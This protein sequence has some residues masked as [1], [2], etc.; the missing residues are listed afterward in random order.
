MRFIYLLC[1]LLISGSFLIAQPIHPVH[2]CRYA[3]NLVHPAKPTTH[4]KNLEQESRLRSDSIDLLNYTIDLEVDFNRSEVVGSCSIDFMP[5]ID[6]TQALVLDLLQLRIDSVQLDGEPIAYSYDEF[7]INIPL[8]EGFDYSIQ[9]QVQVHY[10][11]RPTVAASGFGG[12]AFAGNIAY[13]LGIGLGENPYN[14]GRSWF[15]CFDNFVERAT[16]DLNIISSGNNK[17]YCSG[18]FIE[19]V[20]LNDNQ[21]RRS[22]RINEPM[23]TYLVGI[24]VSTFT[25]IESSHTGEYGTYPIQLVAQPQQI[26]DMDDSF[27]FLGDAVDAL[28]SW[29]GPYSW[30]RIGYVL[31]PIGAMEHVH[32]IAYPIATGTGGPTFDQNRLMAHE[33]AHQWW[34]NVTTLSS[35][36]NMWIKE[37]NAEYGAHLFTEYVQGKEAF[38]AQMQS[39]QLMVLSTAHLADDGFQPLSGIPYE[40]TYGV[41]TYNK[42][43]AVLHN[44]RSYMGDSLFSRAQTAVLRDLAFTSVD[45][46]EYRDYLST[47][48][49]LDMGPFFDAWI[50]APGF[51]DYE[52]DKMTVTE[53]G[54]NYMVTVEVQQKLRATEAYHNNEPVAITFFDE[55]WTQSTMQMRA[56]GE[57]STA[58]FRMPFAPAM[59][60][61][62]HEQTLNM[63]RMNRSYP[64]TEAGNLSGGAIGFFN[65]EVTNLSDSA[66][67][68][69]VHHWTAPDP[70]QDEGI[71][72][73]NTHYW[74]VRQI[75]A[76]DFDA[77][78]TIRFSGSRS[79]LDFDLV[80]QG[81][82]T[83]QMLYRPNNDTEWEIYADAEI[84]PLGN[85]GLARLNTML[86]GDYTLANVFID[87]ATQDHLLDAQVTVSPNPTQDWLQLDIQHHSAPADFDVSLYDLSGRLL[88]QK[89]YPN[90]LAIQDQWSLNDIAA[91]QYLLQISA[92]N[93]TRIIEVV[94]Q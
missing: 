4:Q 54:D 66:L 84:I 53:D 13:N 30:S 68:N 62:N 69:I 20:A 57:F 90:Q 81:V 51:S 83:V 16:F 79:E 58:T 11:G 29:Y 80:A 86:P 18:D 88:Q 34:G 76:E 91:G 2:G 42:G 56:S 15:P 6:Q 87:V 10:R 59:A 55:D 9:H 1:C 60:I 43:A 19:E 41:H 27:V 78:G 61:I 12:L 45:A 3:K 75:A 25:T 63:G 70:A 37:G 21:I 52:L 48:S 24:A 85:G 46:E 33:L 71:Q 23:T 89:T 50:F 8:P 28:E 72:V 65:I 32:N 64:V 67:L 49:G 82:E 26:G 39:N 38:V 93:R 44:M 35:P 94:K 74:S 36:A 22:Y 73:S 31:T 47:A 14:Y 77:K 17:A 7:Q 40:Q 5:I 92:D